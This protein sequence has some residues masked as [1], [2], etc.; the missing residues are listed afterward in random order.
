M[1]LSFNFFLPS[2]YPSNPPRRA[3]HLIFALL[4]VHCTSQGASRSF[5]LAV[6]PSKK[7][8]PDKHVIVGLTL[9]K[10]LT[11]AFDPPRMPVHKHNTASLSA[12]RTSIQSNPLAF[13]GWRAWQGAL[14]RRRSSLDELLGLISRSC[15]P[16]MGWKVEPSLIAAHAGLDHKQ[17]HM[18]PESKPV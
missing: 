6:I 8:H 10:C 9:R 14:V 12:L 17:R 18:S 1:V 4:F 7:N 2:N 11:C 3:R 5:L 15:T 16:N 13:A